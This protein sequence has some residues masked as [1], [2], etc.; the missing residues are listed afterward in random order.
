MDTVRSNLNSLPLLRS[1]VKNKDLNYY[2]HTVI[3]SNNDHNNHIDLVSI[4]MTSSNRSAQTYYTLKTISKSKHKNVQVIIVDDSDTDPISK[5]KLEEFGLFIEL[6]TIKRDKKIWKNPCINYNIGFE[7]VKGN[8]IIIQNAEVCHVGDVIS[9]F[10]SN[11]RN[12]EYY[13]YDVAAVSKLSNNNKI[14]Q[15]DNLNCSIY[16]KP[17]IFRMWYQHRSYNRSLHF[18][19]GMD[20]TTFQ[21]VKDFS[22]DYSFVSSYDDDDFLLKINI[23]N[24][25]I[26]L[27][28]NDM[29][30]VG[31]IHLYHDPS[32]TA[33]MAPSAEELFQ[34]KY[35]YYLKHKKYFEISDGPLLDRFNILST[36]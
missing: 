32:T 3:N 20:Y 6:I 21:K 14:Y 10:T 28:S 33:S 35:K 36:T 16:T 18:L 2:D 19:T 29:H 1:L 34:L 12:N 30:N 4:I 22:Y 27:I 11:I 26:I 7:Y 17:D 8:K 5:D 15:Q 23:A 24:I 25:K 13:V 9:Q 31:G